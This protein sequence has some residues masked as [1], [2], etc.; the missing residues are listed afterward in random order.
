M[1]NIQKINMIKIQFIFLL[2]LILWFKI[3]NS[4]ILSKFRSIFNFGKKKITF[5]LRLSIVFI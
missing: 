1:Q 2:I 5:L 4:I 3:M